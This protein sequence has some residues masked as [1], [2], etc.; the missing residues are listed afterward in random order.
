MARG[1][2]YAGLAVVCR[3][4]PV[5]QPGEEGARHRVIL[6]LLVDH[7]RVVPPDHQH[8]RQNHRPAYTLG[9]LRATVPVEG[10]GD[11]I[12]DLVSSDHPQETLTCFTN[13]LHEGVALGRSTQ[14][15]IQRQLGR[16]DPPPALKYRAPEIMRNVPVMST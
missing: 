2:C 10:L 1:G 11:V 4:E 15:M 14:P 5:A 7:R 13:A 6:S 3:L 9:S 16:R 12:D 8:Q